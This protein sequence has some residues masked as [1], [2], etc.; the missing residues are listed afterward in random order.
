MILSE[1]K[2]HYFRTDVDGDLKEHLIFNSERLSNASVTFNSTKTKEIVA[3][4]YLFTFNIEGQVSAIK[5]HNTLTFNADVFSM[6]G[7]SYSK[8]LTK[9]KIVGD[10]FY[11]KTIA[12]YPNLKVKR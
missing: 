6:F 4:K 1:E 9:N 7:S 8:T 12:L 10:E 2:M 11:T 3:Y 5:V